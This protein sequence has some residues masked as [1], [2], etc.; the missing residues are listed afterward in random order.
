MLERIEETFVNLKSFLNSSQNDI[1][2]RDFE[3]FN[4]I[5]GYSEYCIKNDI[6]S[7]HSDYISDVFSSFDFLQRLYANSPISSALTAFVG[8]YFL[9]IFNMNKNLIKN[10][11]LSDRCAFLDRIYKDNL[12]VKEIFIFLKELN[13]QN[14]NM[15]NYALPSVEISKHYLESFNEKGK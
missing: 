9:L 3:L 2:G 11:I 14:R 4:K 6:E 10:E 1:V 15:M 8:E 5:V 12:T 13:K 7:L